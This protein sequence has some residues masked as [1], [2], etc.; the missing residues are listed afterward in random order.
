MKIL[1]IPSEMRAQVQAWQAAQL[2]IGFVPTMGNLHEG[3]LALVRRARELSDRVV[4][5]VFVNPLQFNREDDL[6]EYPRTIES[7]ID[8][9][10]AEDVD[11]VFAPDEAEMYPRGR[12]AEPRLVIPQLDALMGELE[13][14]SRPGH[15]A[16]VLTVV[17]KLFDIVQP[18]VTIFGEKDF[19]QLLLIRRMVEIKGL[20]V[21]IV[22]E[23]TVREAD[24]LAMSSRNG[25]LSVDERA[26][27]PALFRSLSCIREGLR[28]GKSFSTLQAQA[29]TELRQA[30]FV[31]EY[32]EL[33]RAA[34]LTQVTGPEEDRVIL[35]AAW[36]GRARL[37]DN[38]RV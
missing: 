9:L 1:R 21:Q 17:A 11:A 26:T 22:A 2:R 38:L 15:F 29:D 3:H 33:R 24:G 18:N 6:V 10:A 16:G 23:P 20:P 35:A 4:A 32:I 34:D 37:I 8:K 5:S 31:P 14:A 30:G 27:A 13:G 28:A 36:L 19:Q 7:D 25:Y 12:E